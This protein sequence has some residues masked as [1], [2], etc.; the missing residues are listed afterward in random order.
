MT[1]LTVTVE[2]AAYAA[3]SIRRWAATLRLNGRVTTWDCRHLHHSPAAATKCEKA[4][5][6]DAQKWFG[7][8]DHTLRKVDPIAQPE[9]IEISRPGTTWGVSSRRFRILEEQ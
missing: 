1:A 7:D 8:P 4:L 5:L 9:L 6:A 3:P 2:P